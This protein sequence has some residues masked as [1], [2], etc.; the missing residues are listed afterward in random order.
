[1]TRAF[2]RVTAKFD[3]FPE[4]STLLIPV[5]M[6]FN[7]ESRPNGCELYWSDGGTKTRTFVQED[8]ETVY[9]LL[10]GALP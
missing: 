4:P 5:D 2:I 9:G 10:E 8:V 1:M 7:A 6:I 3:R